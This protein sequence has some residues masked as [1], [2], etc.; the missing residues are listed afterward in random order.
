M[1]T[2]NTWKR[3]KKWATRHKTE[4]VVGVMTVAA[5]TVSIILIGKKAEELN[6]EDQEIAEV[7]EETQE[8][9]GD[10]DRYVI[11]KDTMEKLPAGTYDVF[12]MYEN[13]RVDFL[14]D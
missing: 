14:V 10:G 4:I 12:D 2:E 11:D 9:N 7:L 5:G 6:D 1:K 3:F 8:W 13:E